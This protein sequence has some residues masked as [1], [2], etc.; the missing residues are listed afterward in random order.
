MAGIGFHLR[1]SL[2]YLYQDLL[3][4]S[5]TR[6]R[7]YL[8]VA[9]LEALGVGVRTAD[10]IE[11]GP[12]LHGDIATE[13]RPA[14]MLSTMAH[15]PGATEVSLAAFALSAVWWWSPMPPFRCWSSACCSFRSVSASPSML[16][17]R[18]DS[19]VTST[20]HIGSASKHQCMLQRR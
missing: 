9:V 4:A 8:C 5:A 10:A 7:R 6:V 19:S 3:P 13:R 20:L 15:S 11:R 17:L 12:E 1:N 14:L 18:A 16:L 2:S